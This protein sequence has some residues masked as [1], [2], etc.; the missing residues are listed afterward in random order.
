MA[1]S[2]RHF[3]LLALKGG[4]IAVSLA[5]LFAIYAP[6]LPFLSHWFYPLRYKDLIQAQARQYSLD[7]LFVAAIIR[8]ES[9]FKPAAHSKVGAIGLMQLMPQTAEWGASALKLARFKPKDLENPS[10]NI[11]L[12]CWYLHHLFQQFHDP[13]MVLA[14]YNG[15]EGNVSLWGA[16]EGDQLHHAFPE[17]QSYVNQG[18]RTY[19]RYKALYPG[20]FARVALHFQKPAP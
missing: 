11:Q 9:G 7:P 18:M 4:A 17:T 3:W 14:A 20:A 13:A 8:Q 2:S 1:G 19:A 16:L 12:G 15:G 10:I 6:D 5:S